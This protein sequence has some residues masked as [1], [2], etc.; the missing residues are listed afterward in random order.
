MKMGT[1]DRTTTIPNNLAGQE[2]LGKNTGTTYDDPK[3]FEGP[4]EKMTNARAM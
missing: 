3:Y 1:N 2:K 4:S